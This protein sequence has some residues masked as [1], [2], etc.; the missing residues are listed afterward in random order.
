MSLRELVSGGGC[1]AEGGAAGGANAAAAFADALLGASGSKAQEGQ[2]RTPPGASARGACR[3][4]S[5]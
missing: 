3:S 1:S 4:T 2:L 5:H